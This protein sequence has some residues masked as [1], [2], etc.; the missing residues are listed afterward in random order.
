MSDTAQMRDVAVRRT[1]SRLAWLRQ[2][3]PVR[4]SGLALPA[5]LVVFVVVFSIART[6]TFLTVANFRTLGSSQAVLA[7][8]AIAA[9]LPLI[10]G[11]F[12]LSVGANLGLGVIVTTGLTGNVGLPTP[13]AI[14]LALIT[15]AFV[16]L[17]NGVLVA[18]FE[19]NAFVATL[20]TAT[21][22]GGLVDWV[23]GGTAIVQNIPGSLL[24]LGQASVLG[25]PITV[26]YLLVVAALVFYV[27]R[28][29]PAGRYLYAIGGSREAAR[30]AGIKVSRLTLITFIAAGL[31]AGVAGVMEAAV[32]GSGSPTVGPEFLLPAFAA[33]FLGATSIRPGTFNVPGTVIAVYTIATG[34]T[35][36]EL[37]GTPTY[38]EPIFSGV[39]LVLAALSTRYIRAYRA[40][41]SP[42][43]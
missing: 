8:L 36:L 10:V 40:K 30:L 39:V 29:T 20:A 33:C 22:L 21:V 19:I 27:L 15:C 1:G 28:F 42:S 24:T 31:L 34:T 38:I 32:L 14:V 35:G 7:V 4:L 43:A 23:T 5:M 37:M 6:S 41:S 16:G 3:D 2:W 11:Q 13:V 25:V 17:V 26:I 9:L 18:R 12:D